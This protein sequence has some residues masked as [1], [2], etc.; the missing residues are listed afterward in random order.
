MARISSVRITKAAAALCTA[1]LCSAGMPAIVAAQ[2][3]SPTQQQVEPA[4]QAPSA[5]YDFVYATGPAYCCL[6][7]W[8]G[9]SVCPPGERLASY[10]DWGC[11]SGCG[12]F[13]C[14]TQGSGGKG[15]G[16]VCFQ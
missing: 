3:L 13:S 16:P 15:G 6:D 11:D 14:V 1:L 7:D 4:K 10:C 12:T 5:G 2:D 9:G 8:Q